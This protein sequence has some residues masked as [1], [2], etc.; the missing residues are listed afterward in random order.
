MMLGT[1][2]ASAFT[3]VA[4]SNRWWI[5]SRRKR[6]LSEI[7][8]ILGCSSQTE[9]AALALRVL[10]KRPAVAFY[11]VLW[12]VVNLVCSSTRFELSLQKTSSNFGEAFY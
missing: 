12:I 6:H 10:N 11:C 5:L 9:T 3:A 4:M 8:S 7:E 1:N 2:L